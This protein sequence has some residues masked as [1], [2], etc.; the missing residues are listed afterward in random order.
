MA[1]HL[2]HLI[3]SLRSLGCNVHT[4]YWGRHSDRESF[5]D[6]IIGRLGDIYRIRQTLRHDSFD[7]IFIKTSHDWNTL[8]RD[9]LLL[10]ITCKLRPPTVLQLHGSRSDWL[11]NSGHKPF[12]LISKYL[13]RMSDAILVL[14]SEEENHWRSFYP[15]GKNFVVCNPFVPY[16][17]PLLKKGLRNLNIKGNKMV[18]IFVGRIMSEKGI[19]DLID[20]MPFIKREIPCH[21][22][23]VGEGPEENAIRERIKALGLLDNVTLMGYIEGDALTKAYQAADVFV[24][25]TYYAEGFPTVISEA[26]YA[27]LPIVTTA[28]RGIIDHL[29]EGHNALFVPPKNSEKL[30]EAIVR[31]LYDQ[32]LRKR[33]EQ[34]NHEEVKKF[35]PINVVPRYLEIF[36]EVIKWHLENG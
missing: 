10:L 14:S 35:L 1:K 24:L 36:K 7:I 11:D 2:P 3:E 21:L 34:W 22:I 23:I 5:I 25:P 30:T 29:I 19:F 6:K 26:M 4:E 8:I 32:Q 17:K 28:T 31:L 16:D 33:M 12:K 15:K 13:L 9:V 27:G 20:A 18:I